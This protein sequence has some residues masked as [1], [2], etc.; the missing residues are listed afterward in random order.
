ML[1]RSLYPEITGGASTYLGSTL[2]LTLLGA[3]NYTAHA[4]TLEDYMPSA[5]QLSGTDAL[6]HHASAL[7]ATLLLCWELIR[8]AAAR[9]V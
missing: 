2:A 1:T 6:R 7:G 5:L 3:V 8:C 9:G 4:L